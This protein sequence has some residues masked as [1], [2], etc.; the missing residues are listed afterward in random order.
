M[1]NADNERERIVRAYL[2]QLRI[3]K[4]RVQFFCTLPFWLCELED[5]QKIADQD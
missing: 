4:G 1:G 5:S 2:K 3:K